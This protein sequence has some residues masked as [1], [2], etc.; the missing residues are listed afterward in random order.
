MVYSIFPFQKNKHIDTIVLVVP[1]SRLASVRAMV[2]QYKLD[3]VKKIVPGGKR[4]Q[5]SVKNGLSYLR[6]H[7]GVII[8]HDGVRPLVSQALVNKGIKLCK[9]YKA[10]IF[11]L[12]IRDTVKKSKGNRIQCTVSRK[13]LFLVQTPQ[14]FDARLIKNAAEKASKTREYTDEAAL[15]ETLDIPVYL[16]QGQYNNIKITR[17]EDL[18][19][20][21]KIV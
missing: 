18:Q 13:N 4:R 20:I 12:P 8:I 21:E 9:K 17:K 2:R 19:L 11:G 5:D 6:K 1:K 15:L 3:K 14:F 16:F 10:V 7:K